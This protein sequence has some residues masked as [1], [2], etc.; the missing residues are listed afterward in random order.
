MG[1]KHDA[2]TTSTVHARKLKLFIN[3][4]SN[5]SVAAG[6]STSSKMHMFDSSL[7]R[8]LTCVVPMDRP[9]GGHPRDG[10]AAAATAYAKAEE[11]AAAAVLDD[12]DDY[13]C[14]PPSLLRDTLSSRGCR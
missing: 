11:R 14:L 1:K 8:V 4:T 6:R 10:V 3:A 5:I 12:D 13:R 7:L 9:A 2:E